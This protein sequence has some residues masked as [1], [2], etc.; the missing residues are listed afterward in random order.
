MATNKNL[1][2]SDEK[3]KKST[4][5]VVKANKKEKKETIKEVNNEIFKKNGK[6]KRSLY[7]SFNTRVLLNLFFVI[8]IIGCLILSLFVSF[9]I[10]KTKKINYSNN[11]TID[12]KVYLNDNEFYKEEYLNKGMAYV[13]SL[14]DKIN[15]NFNY[16]FNSDIR[17]DIE[18]KSKVIAKLVISSQNN[19]K[20]FYENEYDISKEETSEIKNE[21]I[22][23]INK[24]VIIDYDYYNDLAN[25]FKSQYA[26]NAD[27]YLEVYLLV[28]EKNKDN[29]SYKINSAQKASLVIPLSQQEINIGLEEKNINEDKQV[30]FPPEVVITDVRFIILDVI[31]FVL[32]VLFLAKFLKKITLISSKKSRYDKYVNKLLRGY[33]RLI[34]NVKT[35]PNFENYNVIKVE[36]FDELLDVRDNVKE[37]IKYYVIIEHQKCEFFIT[38]NNDLY[39]YVVK[40]IDIEK[41]K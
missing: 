38:N 3:K 6:L 17:S 8:I 9:S 36:S 22:H 18:F 31:L 16:K 37:P 14:I 25:K 7:L 13:A 40:A 1:K 35:S 41:N 39:L 34:V 28:S 15:I 12:Y 4:V 21:N 19:S 33:D 32:A 29:N 27:S 11:S 23:S 5:K 10:T 30:V 20:V 24:E 26:V 2:K